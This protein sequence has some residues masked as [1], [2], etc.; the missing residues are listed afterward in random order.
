[1]PWEQIENPTIRIEETAPDSTSSLGWK[2]P[3]SAVNPFLPRPPPLSL[4][5]Y[6]IN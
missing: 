2:H 3:Y 6:Q 4:N 1:M 5:S